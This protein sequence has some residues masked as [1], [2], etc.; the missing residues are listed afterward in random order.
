MSDSSSNDDRFSK[1]ANAFIRSVWGDRAIG[2]DIPA[3]DWSKPIRHEDVLYLLRLYPY[4]Q[5]ISS[6]PQWEETIIPQFRRAGSGWL[7]HDYG[8]AMSSSP[9]PYLYGPGNPEL[10]EAKEREGG[11]GG[12]GFFSVTIQ[13]L[14]TAEAMIIWAMEKGWPGVEI[15][16]GTEFMKWAIWMVTQ[17]RNYPSLGFEPSEVDK[18]KHERIRRLRAEY[19][20]KGPQPGGGSG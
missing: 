17:D 8:Q 20:A 16:S 6:N 11:E 12:G 13:G 2:M 14:I 3:I 15:I 5:I 19:V 10:G 9:G 4:V 18:A 1:A 7:I